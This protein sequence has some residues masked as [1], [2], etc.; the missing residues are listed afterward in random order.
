[1]ARVLCAL[2]GGVDSSVAAVLL[3][4]AGHDVVGVF[5]RN[6]IAGA[7]AAAKSCCSASDARDA[8]RVAD[9]LG[10]PFY[11]V[12]YAEEFA[13]L[14]AR[15]RAEY[16]AGR[17][18]SPCVLCNQDLK[19]GHLLDLAESVG[20]S[21]VA[22]GHYARIRD[23]VVSRPA[24]RAKDQ[25]YFL[26]G[27]P[28]PA[29]P[30]IL[31]PLG[32]Q[33]K[34][35]VRA[36]ARARGL[37][38]AEKAESMEIC[39][40]PG[41]DYRELLRAEGPLTEGR[42][43]DEAGCDLGPHTGFEAYTVGQRRGL[44]ALGEPRY[45]IA[46]RPTTREVVVGRREALRRRTAEIEGLRWLCAPPSPGDELGVQAQI[47]AR[48]Q[49]APARVRVLEGD[50]ARVE[51]D[52]PQEAITPGQAAVLYREERLLGGGWIAGGCLQV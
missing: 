30:R 27:I 12:D 17:T 18:P 47:R 3:Q 19:F 41:G 1:M 43:V 15:F 21:H 16:R 10:I 50:R 52:E 24:D 26:F 49:P 38:T 39:F 46:V 36:I 23:G 48:H 2:S 32:E 25:T 29:L 20:A 4:E 45:V 14:V 22:T 35:E 42:F 51:F 40:V 9:R 31:F 34:D 28:R 7:G 37:E 6:G 5:M 11:A 44:P 8:G 33:R 13:R